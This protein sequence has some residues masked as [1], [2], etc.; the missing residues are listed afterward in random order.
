MKISIT[1]SIIVSA[2]RMVPGLT[3]HLSGKARW[4]YFTQNPHQKSRTYDYYLTQLERLIQSVHDGRLGGDFVDIMSNLVSGQL[5][6]AFEQAWKDEGGD[7]DVPDYLS[8]AAES[9]I[10]NEYDFV[11]GL[12]KDIVDARVDETPIEP[13]LARAAIWANRWTEAYNQAVALIAS[14]NG[15][16]LVWRL[17]ATEQHCDS[18]SS[19]NGIVARASEWE[20]LG[21]HPQGA[22]NDLLLCGGWKCDCSLESTDQRRSPKAYESILNTVSRMHVGFAHFRFRGGPGSGPH[23][24]SGS[25]ALTAEQESDDKEFGGHYEI[26]ADGGMEFVPAGGGVS[27][28]GEDNASK[29]TKAGEPAMN[30]RAEEI[31]GGMSENSQIVV[32]Q[33]GA[34]EL[35]V[36]SKD[37]MERVSGKRFD[38]KLGEVTGLTL[39]DSNSILILD[40]GGGEERTLVHESAHAIDGM[41]ENG[42]F[43]ISEGQEWLDA[44]GWS[45]S[46]D[47]YTL[48]ENATSM[49]VSDYARTAPWEDFAETFATAIN[50]DK[51]DRRAMSVE[52]PKRYEFIK[53]LAEKKYGI[54]LEP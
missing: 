30:A 6:Q 50:G 45:E 20:S 47:G 29:D 35:R 48:K 41:D 26:S 15:G 7:G 34:K 28:D 32:R 37:E 27:A 49:A 54:K 11:D 22:P 24:G 33:S 53:K 25:S 3:A 39:K 21:V 9:M 4:I 52:S 2:A 44:A 18:C 42:R 17:G 13:L 51:Y 46:A 43:E 16:N 40:R 31:V 8:T 12:Y 38:E 36:V 1:R 10:L 5:N 14:E 19:L 23:P